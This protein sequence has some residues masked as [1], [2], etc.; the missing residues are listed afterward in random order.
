ME[1]LVRMSEVNHAIEILL[2]LIHMH[3]FNEIQKLVSK[4]LLDKN[5]TN[6]QK[7]H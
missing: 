3:D 5:K 2:T 4:G 1:K 6:L 7:G